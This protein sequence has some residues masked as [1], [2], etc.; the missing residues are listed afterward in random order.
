MLNKVSSY[1]SSSVTSLALD[2]KK[3]LIKINTNAY[4]AGIMYPSTTVYNSNAICC[5]SK[6][7][8]GS[9]ILDSGVSDNMSSSAEE[10][11]C[12]QPLVHPILVS[13][14]NGYRVQVTH[15]GS[16]KINDHIVLH[17]VLVVPHFKFSLLSV[18]RLAAQLHC[19]VVFTEDLCTLQGPS[20]RS[21]VA[22]G[23]E[24]HGLYI[25]DKALVR[26]VQIDTACFPRFK[27]VLHTANLTS[28]CNQASQQ[29]SAEVWHRR[30]G[31]LPY[32]KLRTLSLTIVFKDS[33]H[34]MFCD[35]WPKAR[36]QRLPFTVSTTA[37]SH[38]FE[39]VHVDTWGPYHTRTHARHRF[40]L[41]IVDDYTKATWTHLMVTKDEAMGLLTTFV[42]M[43][44]TQFS[45]TV[46]TIR[47]DNALEL[48]TSHTAL[49]FFASN[50]I[51]HQTSCVQTPQ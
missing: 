44:H 38:A 3:E 18:K 14:P 48:S 11:H 17:H 21:P 28:S 10:L 25:L 42:R 5:L 47:T 30:V 12:I 34:D 23:R 9:W 4:M 36:Q 51:L 41:T 8:N 32:K 6:L 31:H 20:Q 27:S 49:E 24:A 39:L 26:T 13:L 43:A 2:S 7:E 16:L 40:F 45:A 35:V 37:S 1:A 33:K 22:V 50:G 15:H 29:I 19:Q 46:K